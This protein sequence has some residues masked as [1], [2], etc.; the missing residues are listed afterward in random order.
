[1]VDILYDFLLHKEMREI[2]Y[3]RTITRQVKIT[4]QKKVERKCMTK[5]THIR[6]H[7]YFSFVTESM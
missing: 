5:K 6:Q 1:M 7:D 3:L 4:E 2:V